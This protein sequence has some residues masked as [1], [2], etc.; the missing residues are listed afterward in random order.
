MNGSASMTVSQYILRKLKLPGE[1]MPPSS[2][3][4]YCQRTGVEL[5]Q[6][7]KKLAVVQKFLFSLSRDSYVR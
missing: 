4:K 2:I 6:Q 5:L 7:G 1:L 3:P